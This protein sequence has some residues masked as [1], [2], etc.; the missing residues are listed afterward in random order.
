[1]GWHVRRGKGPT[2]A[3]G[4]LDIPRH[5]ATFLGAKREK[6][7]N[8]SLCFDVFHPWGGFGWSKRPKCKIC[9]SGPCIKFGFPGHPIQKRKV[10]KKYKWLDFEIVIFWTWHP[11]EIWEKPPLA[12]WHLWNGTVTV[13]SWWKNH[14][15]EIPC[16]KGYHPLGYVFV[17]IV[18]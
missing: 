6:N 13:P 2:V 17:G 14:F 12:I 7:S 8:H 9:A 10:H 1:M 4:P 16:K 5:M 3:P 11:F 18:G 15:E